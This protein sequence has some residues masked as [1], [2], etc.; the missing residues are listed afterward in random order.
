MV[1]FQL[2][3]PPYFLLKPQLV[4][5]VSVEEMLCYELKARTVKNHQKMLDALLIFLKSLRGQTKAGQP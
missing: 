4:S 1:D 5:K 3:Q 2:G